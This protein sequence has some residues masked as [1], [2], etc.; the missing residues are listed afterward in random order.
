IGMV[1]SQLSG[2]VPMR[3]TPIIGS[4]DEDVEYQAVTPKHS[5]CPPCGQKGKRTHVLTRRMAHVAALN[6]RSWSVAAVGV[7]QARWAGCKDFQAAMPG[8]PPRGR[9]AWEGRNPVANALSR[10]RMP[11]RSVLR[12]RRE[13]DRLALALGYLHACFLWAPA[14]SNME[15][16]GPV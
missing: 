12:R 16:H 8:V 13:A 2:G 4:Q 1:S 10:D 6:C 15:T 11:D 7:Y 3:Y 5:P 9:Y 14:Q